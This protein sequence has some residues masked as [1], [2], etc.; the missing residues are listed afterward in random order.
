MRLSV[1]CRNYFSLH[2]VTAWCIT[3]S[4]IVEFKHIE[5]IIG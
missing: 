1:L 5:I 3:F 2:T 4:V